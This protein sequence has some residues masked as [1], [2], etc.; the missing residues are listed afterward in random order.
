M[1]CFRILLRRFTK[2][3]I[4]QPKKDHAITIGRAALTLTFPARFMLVSAM[5]P[6][7]CGNFGAAPNEC[8]CSPH[9]V[10]R[11]RARVSGPL[12]DRMDIHIE[13]PAVQYG[14]L[15]ADRAGDSSAVVRARVEA[16][17]Q[18]QLARFAGGEMDGLYCNAHMDTRHIRRYCE[19]T[20]KAE[21]LLRMAIA[22]LAL[23]ARA[24]DRIR[25]VARTVADLEGTESIMPQH[26][27]KAVQYRSLDRATVE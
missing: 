2:K 26:I 8:I 24:Y 6:C 3:R 17:R 7:P 10:Q 4:R 23:S 12:L 15:T 19:V 5:N 25:K 1:C 13:V 20:G 14:D 11:Y 27:G 16:A 18:T 22:R 9:A 21:E